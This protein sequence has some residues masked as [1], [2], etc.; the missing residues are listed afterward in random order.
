[1]PSTRLLA[2]YES[3]YDS[4][5]RDTGALTFSDIALFLAARAHAIRGGVTSITGS[6]GATTTGCSTNSRI[7]AAPNGA[8]FEP[9]ADEIIQDTSAARTF[10]YVGDTKQAIYGWRGGDARLFWEIRDHYNRGQNRVVEQ[11]KLEISH[12]SSRA[13]VNI[14]EHVLNPQMLTQLS[15]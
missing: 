9:L 8:S 12:R 6:T 14:V 2:R 1:M 10:F 11:E 13:I 4:T 3:V 5:V 7:P 15:R